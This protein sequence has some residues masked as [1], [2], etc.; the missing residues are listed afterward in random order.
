V[1]NGQFDSMTR[2]SASRGIRY[3]APPGPS[4]DRTDAV[5]A[6]AESGADQTAEAEP[7]DERNGGRADD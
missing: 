7:V 3:P 1:T 5:E 4:G 2:Y 6:T